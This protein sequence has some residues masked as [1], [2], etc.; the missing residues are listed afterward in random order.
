V[1]QLSMIPR[2]VTCAILFSIGGWAQI[3]S[4]RLEGTVWTSK[5]AVIIGATVTAADNQTGW[6]IQT[7][8]VALGHFVFPAL[9]PG[10]YTVTIEAK[11]FTSAIH[12]NVLLGSSNFIDERFTLTPD[13]GEAP[14]EETSRSERIGNLQ[15][16]T[17]GVFTNE[18]ISVLPQ[19]DRDPVDLFPFQPGVQIRGGQS[20]RSGVNG[21]LQ[22][23]NKVSVDGLGD[24]DPV[25]PSLDSNVIARNANTIEQMRVITSGGE[26]EF[27]RNAGAQVMLT[28]RSGGNRW[29]GNG[30]LY[31]RNKYL[32]ARDYFSGADKLPYF[33]NLFGFSGGG[34]VQKNRTFIFANYQRARATDRIPHNQTVLTDDA[35]SGIFTWTP[36]GKTTASTFDIVANDPRHLGIDPKVAAVLA[37]M[38]EYNNND[39]GDG[40][41][42]A[43]FRFNSILD[44]REDQATLRIDHNLR[45]N[46]R[47]FVRGSWLRSQAVDV[48][49]EADTRYPGLPS[50]LNLLQS[51]GFAAGSEWSISPTM[52]NQFR[53][54]Y[55]SAKMSL[56]R[57]SRTAAPMLVNS[58][59]TNPL[60]PSFPKWRN[61]PIFELEN[62]LVYVRG[63]HNFKAGAGLRRITLKS[64]SAEG[65]Y[66]TVTF[67]NDN[68]NVPISVG[69]AG[70]NIGTTDREKFEN[71]YNDLLGR[72][73]EVTQT[74][75]SDLRTYSPVGTARTRD[76]SSYEFD[77]FIQDE[78]KPLPNLT[79][80]LGVRYEFNGPPS[81]RNGIQAAIDR[82]GEITSTANINNLVFQRGGKLYEAD[83]ANF[84]PRIGFAWRPGTS[85]RTVVRGGFGIY[86]DRL[87]NT[88]VAFVDNNTV[89]SYQAF[90][91][92]P[93]LNGTDVRLSDG[94]PQPGQPGAVSLSLP[95][96]RSTSAAIFKGDLRTPYVKQFS[97][98]AQR[99]LF[100][101][102]IV[103][104]GYVGG[105]GGKLFT[106]L[107][108][109]QA[110]ISGDFLTAFKQLQK[111]RSN[112]VPVPQSNTLVRMFG[113][114]NAAITALGGSN[115]D[116]GSA[117]LAAATID[118]D[119]FSNYAAAGISDFYI[120]NYPQFDKLYVGTNDGKSSYDSFQGGVRLY[121]SVIKA[122]VNYTWSKSLDDLSVNGNSYVSP[123][124]S[125][126]PDSNKAV[127][128]LNRTRVLN[129][130]VILSLPFGYGRLIGSDASGWRGQFISDWNF[131]FLIVR[132]SGARFSASSGL[133]TFAAGADSLANYSGSRNIG[134]I[135]RQN[136]Q[137]YWFTA[138]EISAFTFPGAGETGTSGRNS[139]VGPGYFNVDISVVKGFRFGEIRRLNL[140]AEAYNAFN[141][142]NFG[143]PNIN[144]SDPDNF[145]KITTM[146]GA[147]RRLQL[148]LQFEF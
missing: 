113:S 85:T 8:T 6:R 118:R 129:S 91:L 54:G 14:T 7:E 10:T 98:I 106:N 31:N 5:G 103:Q 72:M 41:N 82:S 66:P 70:R 78:W 128:D 94:V 95:A 42:T 61:A 63:K 124:D 116:Q 3:P 120:R 12:Y 134:A 77:A 65:I 68:G 126:H 97:M 9:P 75:Y 109:N 30:F 138:N 80:N 137:I 16:E 148:A 111:F 112:G 45:G 59:W 141:N 43:G 83:N 86:Y 81:E 92:Y 87:V 101:N 27:G 47:L 52:V 62:N 35:K 44:S 46:N 2:I 22:G 131:G 135:S 144:L 90:S 136:R 119:Y 28:T 37:L 130:W 20:G 108:L 139:F 34:P 133:E 115:L 123:L 53:I 25:D 57:P 71:L 125:L 1:R 29:S 142:A 50:G 64:Q 13:V 102:F 23:S 11:G 147:P 18:D 39:I 49:N 4:T 143:I 89:G 84:A 67:G 74:F 107:N 121:T 32:K 56:T 24:N 40:V 110:K 140:R 26:A 114:V 51:L 105:R 127:S 17:S 36:P 55:Q 96:T 33:Q 117:G 21:A 93:N 132:E 76:F 122:S 145:G 58:S 88:A 38:P 104:G 146:A 48:L 99:E 69:P 19:L 73:E 60:D 79:V 15:S 100:R